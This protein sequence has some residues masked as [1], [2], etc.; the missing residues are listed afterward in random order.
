M[1]E[2][3]KMWTLLL[4]L[5]GHNEHEQNLTK[6]TPNQAYEMN[7]KQKQAHIIIQ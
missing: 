5:W 6:Y 3:D 7:V 2:H 1:Y 4:T